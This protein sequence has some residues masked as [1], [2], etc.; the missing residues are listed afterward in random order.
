MKILLLHT[1]YLQK[2][3]EDQVFSQDQLL[4]G[5]SHDV[6][7]LTFRN[8]PGWKGA[9][10]F[11][12][13]IWNIGAAKRLK[14][15]I[16][17]FRPDVIHVHN[18]HFAI[19]PIAL[20]VIH[21]TGIPM[22]V[23]LH[24]YRLLCPSTTL[25]Y[26]GRLFT[27]S[28]RASFPLKAI[29]NKVYRNSALQTFWLAFVIWVHKLLGTWKMVDRYIVLTEFARNVFHGS[30]FGVAPERYVVK[31]NFLDQA[32][33]LPAV[34][35]DFFLFVGRLSVEK[36]LHVLLEAF[37]RT[38]EKLLIVGDGPMQ[39]SVEE[40]CGKHGNITW[41][42]HLDGAGVREMMKQCT[43]LVFPSIWY[44]G[45]PMTLLESFASGTPV[46]A[47]K[48]GAME[49]MIAEGYNGLHFRSG[50]AD[51]LL[52][53]VRYWQTLSGQERDRFSANAVATYEKFYTPDN[54]LERSL[55]IYKSVIGT[56]SRVEL[57]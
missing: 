44:E 38:D 46:I 37:G 50:D 33:T 40:A 3:G 56:K 6:R 15:T 47:S 55:T 14:K 24:N 30:S 5:R 27:D 18:L 23:T 45:M 51:D 41:S 28:L 29:S 42:G 20:R 53:R 8:S 9:L 2:G 36:G 12:F 11:L 49:T 52:A 48:I 7:T 31:P 54:N 26:K 1:F 17:E 10:Q 39:R 34:R 32:S 43:A 35:K 25:V 4:L 21:K 57:T 19:G 13:S 22:V 16:E